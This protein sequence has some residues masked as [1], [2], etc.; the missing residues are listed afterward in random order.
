[1]YERY[2]TRNVLPLKFGAKISGVIKMK[3]LYICIEVGGSLKIELAHPS[4]I[5]YKFQQLQCL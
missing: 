3:A 1:M 2:E 5:L 4:A